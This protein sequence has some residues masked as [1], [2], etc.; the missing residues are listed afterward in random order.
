MLLPMDHWKISL[1]IIIIDTNINYSYR[2][3]DY[4]N[5][6]HV[7]KNGTGPTSTVHVNS[8]EGQLT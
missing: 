8:R 4:Y 3:A 5:G 2:I 1:Y 6:L 7:V